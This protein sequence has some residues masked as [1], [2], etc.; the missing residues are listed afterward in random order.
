[1]DELPKSN[2]LH[3]RVWL[4]LLQGIIHSKLSGIQKD[5]FSHLGSIVTHLEDKKKDL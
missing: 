4:R 1:M 5:S 3:D 2:I